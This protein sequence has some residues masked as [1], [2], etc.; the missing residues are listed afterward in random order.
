[1][2]VRMDR[3]ERAQAAMRAQGIDAYMVLTHDDYQYLMGEDRF[4]PRAVIPAEGPPLVICFQAEAEEIRR[5][6]GTDRVRVFATVG[7]QIKDVVETMRA[8]KGDRDKLRVGIQMGFFT[9]FFLVSMFQKANPFIEIA[10]IGPVMDPLRLRKDDEERATMREAARLADLGMQVAHDMLRPGVR[11]RDVALEL[12]YAMRKAGADGVAVPVFI[13]SGARAMWL[14]GTA[15]DKA[16]EAGETVV[17]N[18]VPKYRGYCA[19][20]CRTFFVG[21]P[22]EA[23]RGLYETYRAMQRAALATMRPG[24][25]MRAVDDAAKAVAEAAGHGAHYVPGFSHSLGLMFEEN[26]MPR[27]HPNHMGAGLVA[28]MAITAGH[29]VL[30]VPGVGAARLEDTYWL[31]EAGP[32][33]MTRYPQGWESAVVGEPATSR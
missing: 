11:E 5:N 20:L 29:A 3:I 19:N 31:G 16:L 25:K 2:T 1:M 8:M 12:E 17:V 27:L 30:A 9:P 14:H 18:L 32:E 33:P 13:N 4:Q 21:E 23:Q 24:A 28:G 22:S 7:Q 26:P 6:L 15:T 10:D